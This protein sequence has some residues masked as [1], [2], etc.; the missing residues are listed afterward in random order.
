ML[1]LRPGD[2]G[3]PSTWLAWVERQRGFLV[4]LI[5][6]RKRGIAMGATAALHAAL[7]APEIRNLRWHEKAE[8]DAG[9]EDGS[10]HP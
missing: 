8:F 1:G 4:S 3:E 7:A 10:P 9:S 2:N 5:G 6:G